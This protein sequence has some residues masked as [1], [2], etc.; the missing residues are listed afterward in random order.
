MITREIGTICN[1][2]GCLSVEHE[3]A[4]FW[5]VLEDVAN[6]SREEIPKY[7]FDALNK[8]QDELD[9]QSPED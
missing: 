1:Y 9:N 6:D 5:W 3:N 7:L 8:F 4:Q 2:Y